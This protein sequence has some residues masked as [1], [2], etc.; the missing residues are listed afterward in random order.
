[1]TCGASRMADTLNAPLLER[2]APNLIPELK[3]YLERHRT[4]LLRM[5]ETDGEAGVQLGC[6]H[7]KIMD[8]LLTALYPA[9]FATMKRQKRW[10]PVLLAAVGGYGRGVVGLKS[11]LDVRLLTTQSPERIRPIAEALLYPLWD[12]GVSIG[13]QVVSVADALSTARADLPTATALLDFRPIA[14]DVAAG[15]LLEEKA[16]GGLFSEGELHT[17][18]G[19]LESEVAERHQRFGASVYLLE[20][21]VKN[22]AGGLRDL[23]IALW[24][25]RARWRVKAFVDLVRL[26][27]LV[28]RE[29]N[30]INAANDFLWTVRNH[31][32][33]P[34]GRR[35]GRL[36]FEEQE[37]TAREM[38]YHAKVGGVS[39]DP[40]RVSGAM[41]EMFM[42]DYYRHAR[43]VTRAREQIISRATPRVGRKRPHEE[44]LG[45]GLRTFDGQITIA[46]ANELSTD[47]ALSLRLYAAAIARSM[48]VLPFARDAIARVARD[49]AFGEA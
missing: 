5:L 48:P 42:S 29:A 47:P 31:L 43:I 25:A 2:V 24:A 45:Q 26:G 44:D 10:A 33:H 35:S 17:F 21:D 14:G 12:V 32:H 39:D 19:R 38:G 13:H 9:A 22:G 7:A 6:R 1:M 4:E 20:P 8:G 27:V 3:A 40:D 49:A 11:D 41:V 36:T 30:E 18:M 23:D 34:G 46:D 15:Q 16:F 37:V 28:P